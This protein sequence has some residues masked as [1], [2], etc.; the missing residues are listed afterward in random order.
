MPK[1][2]WVGNQDWNKK[3]P[4]EK[5]PDSA[6]EIESPDNIFTASAKYG[7]LPMIFCFAC[8]LIKSKIYNEF[9]LDRRFIWAGIVLGLCLIP[10]HE[11]LHAVCC[12]KNAT[13][14]YGISIKKFAAFCICHYPMTKRR[15]I[16]MSLLPMILGVIPLIL[17]L[18]FPISWK[19]SSAICW[20]AAMIGML[21]PMPD[22]MDV[23]YVSKVVPVEAH[24]QSSNSGCFWF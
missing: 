8:L 9:P 12:P 24:I 14:Y 7:V 19:I 17:F 1:I 16:T 6:I 10:V 23:H 11:L 18:T 3:Y 22:Y 15:Y 21:S 13:V 2:K 5:I 20:P 4:E